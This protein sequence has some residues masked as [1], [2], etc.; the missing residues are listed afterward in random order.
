[1]KMH[2]DYKSEQDNCIH[3]LFNAMY[4]RVENFNLAILKLSIIDFDTIVCTGVSEILFA[5]T[6]AYLMKKQLI[7][8]RKSS[9]LD[10]THS[11]KK[12]EANCSPWCVGKYII[13][14]DLV[15]TGSTAKRVKIAV[16]D[17]SS[18]KG[19]FIGAYLYDNPPKFLEASI[20]D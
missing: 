12:I 13:V 19:D 6:L 11:N 4:N 7:I 17:F 5:S 16:N 14:D 18:G 15:S 1:M 9:G 2:V 20:I 10:A 3:Y 8:V